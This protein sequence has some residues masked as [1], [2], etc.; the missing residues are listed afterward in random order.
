[1][2]VYLVQH[3]KATTTEEDPTRGL[4][5]EGREE[6]EHMAKER[7]GTWSVVWAVV[8]DLLRAQTRLAA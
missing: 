3:G 4:S 2:H 7:N 8:P 6:L 5:D 1:M